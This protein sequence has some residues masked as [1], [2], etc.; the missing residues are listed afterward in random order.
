MQ[1]GRTPPLT[2]L[3]REQ[4]REE[5]HHT[6]RE[7]FKLGQRKAVEQAVQELYRRDW[8][9]LPEDVTPHEVIETLA[10]AYE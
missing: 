3:D 9:Q 7:A 2:V 5:L 10:A 6:T 8:L 1:R 4:Y